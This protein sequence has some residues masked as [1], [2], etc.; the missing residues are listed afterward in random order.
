MPKTKA[1]FIEP[2]LLLGTESRYAGLCLGIFWDV[3][4]LFLCVNV[5]ARVRQFAS[6]VCRCIVSPGNRTITHLNKRSWK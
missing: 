4:S 1:T 5:Y 2:M 6:E 3:R